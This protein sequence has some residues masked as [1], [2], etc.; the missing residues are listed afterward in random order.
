MWPNNVD[1]SAHCAVGEG[2]GQR[3]WVGVRVRAFVRETKIYGAERNYGSRIFRRNATYSKEFDTFLFLSRVSGGILSVF[4]GFSFKSYG[5]ASPTHAD[6]RDIAR[7]LTT[8]S[9]KQFTRPRGGR[10]HLLA[11]SIHTSLSAL[12]K[13]RPNKLDP[14]QPKRHL[15][16]GVLKSDQKYPAESPSAAPKT[17]R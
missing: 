13:V 17:P 4:L 8:V 10:M 12:R 3:G 16:V 1:A 15:D 11:R 9:Q 6:K 7:R 5:V 14:A 2:S